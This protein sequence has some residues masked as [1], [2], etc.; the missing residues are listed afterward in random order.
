MTFRVLLATKD[1]EKVSTDLVEFEECDL[2]PGTS[3]SQ[4]STQL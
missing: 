3:R 4:L 1:G 2:M